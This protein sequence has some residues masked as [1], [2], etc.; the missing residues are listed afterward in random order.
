ME[1]DGARA[2]DSAAWG[3]WPAFRRMARVQAAHAAGDALVAVSL[4]G[5]LFFDVPIGE[6]RGKV[7]LYLLLT[8]TP[9][10]VLSP[11]VGPL[12]DRR[13]GAYRLAVIL[14]AIGRTVLAVY[15][16]TRTANLALYPMAFGLL[17]LSRT[18]GVSRSALLPETLPP[19]RSLIAANARM[20]LI[21]VLGGA[22]AALPGAGIQKWLGPGATL[23]LAA[24]AFAYAA[25]VAFS[26]PK[27][28]GR[29]RARVA[30]KVHTLL[31][32]RLLAA[33]AATAASRACVGFGLFLLAF[34]LREQG[35][36]AKGFGAVLAAAGAGGFLGALVAPALRRVFRESLLML[37]SLLAMGAT[38][39]AFAGR[40]DLQAAVIVALVTG[41]GSSAAR[42]A[43]DSL[44]QTE[45]PDEVRGRTFARYETLFQLCWVAGAGVAAGIP[46][47]ASVGLTTL[48]LICVGGIGFALWTAAVRPARARPARE[49]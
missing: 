14:S 22:I 39:F 21:S 8:M 5:T 20:S 7:E 31:S 10:A 26:L 32:P 15:M 34:V 11:I 33:G 13:A 49:R 28:R 27:T 35:E 36:G 24:I 12:L 1:P 30:G 47:S 43:F 44:I 18:H 41:L 3:D 40:F 45:A 46:F 9:F 6:A 48:G 37:V 19:G 29:P 4:A 38:A 2:P 25:I 17:V 42:L 16:A 23:R